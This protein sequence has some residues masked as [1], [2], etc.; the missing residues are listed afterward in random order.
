MKRFLCFSVISALLTLT[1]CSIAPE[2]YNLGKAKV[3]VGMGMG[4]YEGI[5]D[6]PAGFPYD[7][8]IMLICYHGERADSCRALVG[9]SNEGRRIISFDLADLAIPLFGEA[10]QNRVDEIAFNSERWEA[11]R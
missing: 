9:K 8:Q 1:S 2:K 4:M 11:K 10:T 6:V 7:G 5:I 3:E